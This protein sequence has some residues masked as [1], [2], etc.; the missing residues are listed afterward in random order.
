MTYNNPYVVNFLGGIM[1]YNNPYV[2]NFLGGIMTYN[3]PYVVNFL[4][5]IMTY[6]NPYVV[7]Y[8]IHFLKY[9]LCV[10]PDRFGMLL[11]HNDLLFQVEKL[12]CKIMKLCVKIHI[13][14]KDQF[15]LFLIMERY[16][17]FVQTNTLS[18]IFIVLSH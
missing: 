15:F 17:R 3:N 1:T 6:N 16:V 8:F 13:I 4:G 2:V 14:C 12:R 5:G 11:V 18:L 9:V 10:S 7:N